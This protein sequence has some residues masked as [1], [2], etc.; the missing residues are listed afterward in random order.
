MFQ[1][2]KNYFDLNERELKRLNKMLIS[3]NGLEE[4]FSKLSDEKLRSKTEDFKSRFSEGETLEQILPEAFATVRE[5]SKRVL[6]MRHFD[7]QIIGGIVLHEGNISEMKTGEGKTLVSTLPVYLNALTGKG[8]HVIT[9]NEYLA[10]RDAEEMGVLYDFLGLSVGLNLH[11]MTT[12]EK[13]T[14]YQCDIMY[15][16]NNEF[17]FDYLRDNMVRNINDRVIP[18]LNYAVIDEVDSILIDEAR[19]PLII[20]GSIDKPKA[21]Y[22][23]SDLFVRTMKKEKDF[24]IDEKIKSIQ[25]TEE[26]ISKAE[27]YFKIENLFDLKHTELNHHIN[28]SLRAHHIMK[29]DVDYVVFE[30]EVLIVDGF[31]GRIMKG[32]RFSEGL[33][34]AIEAK[35]KVEIQKESMTLAT[36]T[37]QNFFR[38]YKK[39]SGMTGTAKTEEEEFRNIYGMNVIAIPTNKPLIRKDMPDFIYKTKEAKF[40]AAINDII[41]RHET[42][43]PVLVGT[44]DIET[45]EF[46]STLLMKEKIKHTVLN[47]K[48]HEKE[49]EIISNAGQKFAVTIATNMAGRGTDI[50]LGQGVLEVGGLAVIGTERHESRRIDNQLRGRSGRQGDIGYSRFYLSMEDEIMIRFGSEKMTMMLDKLG[51]DETIPIESKMI[52]RA[53][54]NAQ[55]QVEGNNFDTRKRLLQYDDVIREQRDIIY[56]QRNEILESNNVKGFVERMLSSY[57]TNTISKYATDELVPEEWNHEGLLN[58]INTKILSISPIEI[59]LVKRLDKEEIIENVLEKSKSI[60]D[61]KEKIYGE[62][63]LR[64]IEKDLILQIVDKNWMEQIN[65]L[66]QLRQGIHLRAYGQN[67][68]LQE[69]QQASF[70]MFEDMIAKIEEEVVSTIMRL[71]IYQQNSGQFQ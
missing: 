33:H 50:K 10:K 65:Q 56:K 54:E 1:V 71:K 69:Y 18:S 46:L 3:I 25:M 39:L 58:E 55:K 59:A 28:Q 35:E 8:V 47:A 63:V 20:S 27:N 6:N 60:Y 42:G 31:T 11:D 13:Q 9:V 38:M 41:Q 40:K 29:K 57:V 45:S 2:L 22:I 15:G 19:T 7:V 32:R 66:D 44:S 52:T 51:F 70:S 62:E 17:A 64:Q 34:Q 24:I 36:V 48:Q 4:N 49:A 23:Q 68:P 43:Q 37:F 67:D 61:K 14:N 12:K 53:V 16:T 26:G 21:F 30:G 5:A